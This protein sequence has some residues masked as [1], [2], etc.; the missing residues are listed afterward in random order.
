MNVAMK[1]VGLYRYLPID[2]PESLLDL[3][4]PEPEPRGDDLLVRVEAVA[5]N[6]VDTKIRAPKETVRETPHILGWDAA[7]VVESVGPEVKRFEPGD[8]VY[9]SG[10]LHRPGCNAEFHLVE[11]SIVGHA[12]KSLSFAEAAALPLT[13][14]TAWESLFDRLLLDP[15]GKHTG[16]SILILNGAGGVG[17]AAI[18]WAKIA[19]L[20]VIATASRPETIQWCKQLGADHVLNHR[21]PLRPQMETLGYQDI[22]YIA[23]FVD[24][25]GYWEQ[26]GDLIAPQGKIVLIVEPRIPLRIGDPYKFKSVTIAWEM[27]GSRPMLQTEDRGK[28]GEVL[29]YLAG[30]VDSGKFHTTITQ[31]H[32]PINAANLKQAHTLMESGKAVGKCVLQGW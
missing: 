2:H 14:L 15:G 8:R 7:G 11:E 12:P 27:M 29:D 6:P 20:T 18:Q 9:Y 17:S 13:G 21:N 24:T 30:L 23:N 4:I 16:T 26:M 5:V 10:N 31:T 19:G 28:Q 25:D 22:P 1:A 32:S 3:E